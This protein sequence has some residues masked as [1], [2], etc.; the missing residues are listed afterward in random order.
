M[1]IDDLVEA[2]K[3]LEGFY[4]VFVSNETRTKQGYV[5]I[6]ACV[7]VK[8][9]KP[10]QRDAKMGNVILYCGSFTNEFAPSGM[11]F[12]ARDVDLVAW[13]DDMRVVTILGKNGKWSRIYKLEQIE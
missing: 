12:L 1:K 10:F 7:E 5:P 6:Q 13:S 4:I 8:Y 9:L 11:T 3:P 2:L